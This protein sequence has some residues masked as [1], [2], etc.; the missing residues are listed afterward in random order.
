MRARSGEGLPGARSGNGEQLK[1]P[2]GN[3]AECPEPEV[4][5]DSI[6][7]ESAASLKEQGNSFF[8]E[9]DNAGSL[10]KYSEALRSA[11]LA[12]HDRAVLHANC[13]AVHVRLEA[14]KEAKEAATRALDVE[15]T[16]SKALLRRKK[17]AEKLEDWSTAA[18]DAKA[19]GA[20]AG[21]IVALETKAKQQAEREKDE[22]MEQLKGIGN[23]LLSNFGLSLDSFQMDKDP[24]TGSYSI[25]MK[26]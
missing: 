24:D 13:A 2:D 15:P 10:E 6:S 9:G 26:Q 5:D 21:E 18:Q 16:Y 4:L 12:D 1:T 23:S 17:A 14:W 8:K 11:H 3:S 22:A 20:P 7:A 19:L 25:K